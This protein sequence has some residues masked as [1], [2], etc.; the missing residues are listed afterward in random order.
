M[1]KENKTEKLLSN[2][3]EALRANEP[4]LS[5]VSEEKSIESTFKTGD[6]LRFKVPVELSG[7]V[8][9]GAP[10]IA[11]SD[12]YIENDME[13][14][15]VKDPKAQEPMTALVADLELEAAAEPAAQAQ[16]QAVP[17]SKKVNEDAGGSWR[18]EK[19]TMAQ[20]V[21]ILKSKNIAYKTE[22]DTEYSTKKGQPGMSAE[23]SRDIPHKHTDIRIGSIGEQG[24]PMVRLRWYDERPND[25]IVFVY[26][27][28]T[29]LDDVN[30]KKAQEFFGKLTNGILA[31]IEAVDALAGGASS[32]VG[33][34]KIKE[35]DGDDEQAAAPAAA[36]AED[37]PEGDDELKKFSPTEELADEIAGTI[38]IDFKTIDKAQFIKGLEVEQ[39]HIDVTEGDPVIT[40]RIAAAHLKEIPDY[41]TRLAQMEAD[42]KKEPAAGEP[43]VTIGTGPKAPAAIAP[44]EAKVHEDIDDEDAGAGAAPI[45]ADAGNVPIGEDEYL[46]EFERISDEYSK[47]KLNFEQLIVAL[48]ELNA[49]LPP[50]SA[51][52]EHEIENAGEAVEPSKMDVVAADL[53]D[54]GEAK[55][56]QST[57]PGSQI[58]QDPKTKRYSVVLKV[59]ESLSNERMLVFRIAGI[60]DTAVAKEAEKSY[61]ERW[62]IT[63]D[64]VP[65][66][67]VERPRTKNDSE[68]VRR[69][70]FG[71]AKRLR[72]TGKSLMYTGIEFANLEKTAIVISTI[73]DNFMTVV[74]I[75]E[76]VLKVK[77]AITTPD[78]ASVDIEKLD[79]IER[80]TFDKFSPKLGKEETLQIIINTMEGDMS[81]LSDELRVRAEKDTTW[82]NEAK[83]KEAQ[84]TIQKEGIFMFPVME[85]G[86]ELLG[87]NWQREHE[88]SEVFDEL[89]TKRG[90]GIVKGFLETQIKA[91]RAQ[92]IKIV[93]IKYDQTDSGRMSHAGAHY[94]VTLE[95]PAAE[96]AKCMG[97]DKS[98]YSEGR[99]S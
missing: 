16:T 64:N 2:L 28:K 60:T 1:I 50:P 98:I 75:D 4:V 99:K 23:Y 3:Y 58:I 18:G 37:K 69:Y 25:M 80:M 5:F 81:Q 21:S 33:E 95:G 71:L 39:E 73:L 7:K 96:L 6:K 66:G 89:G 82:S 76:G 38:G 45:S 42:A 83:L 47:G 19:F 94:N 17:E 29:S 65:E 54:E 90:L 48:K 93:S 46:K 59:K 30:L 97:E 79:P 15:K 67:W 44:S 51:E 35:A 62:G 36:P 31:G 22:K 74:K 14:I 26:D 24:Y 40:G 56:V 9:G 70:L 78:L 86:I 55:K 92:G 12:P 63:G 77:E 52:P 8:S 85:F 87:K 13:M 61:K 27:G 20:V 41:Y 34:S 43:A 53:S 10:V 84:G 49:K 88:D 91:D 32:K 11:V 57:K 72:E 68:V